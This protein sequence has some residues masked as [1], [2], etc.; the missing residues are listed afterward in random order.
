MHLAE[1]DNNEA[2]EKILLVILNVNAKSSMVE[3]K[4]PRVDM[5]SQSGLV[6]NGRQSI[7][8]NLLGSDSEVPTCVGRLNIKLD[9]NNTHYIL[10][11]GLDPIATPDTQR[12]LENTARHVYN[13]N[14]DNK[15]H[16]QLKF[17]IPRRTA[18]KKVIPPLKLKKKINMPEHIPDC[19]RNSARTQSYRKSR[20]HSVDPTYQRFAQTFG[21]QYHEHQYHYDDEF[22]ESFS[23]VQLFGHLPISSHTTPAPRPKIRST[24][25]SQIEV[26]D[27]EEFELPVSLPPKDMLDEEEN[28]FPPE[29]ADEEDKPFE[30]LPPKP[31]DEPKPIAPPVPNNLPRSPKKKVAIENDQ[32]V[33]VKT[34]SELQA[35][36]K[37]MQKEVDAH[38]GEISQRMNENDQNGEETK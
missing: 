28:Y 33:K 4:M 34:S 17:A 21:Y 24:T 9:W 12:F 18:K 25:P 5:L 8:V 32:P 14:F 16:P 30:I 20:K 10:H 26:S 23:F 13:T 36:L 35:Q 11:Q 29:P 7:P 2:L 15:T 38:I 1:A 3:R 6:F 22:G 37:M 19:E 31:A 27:D